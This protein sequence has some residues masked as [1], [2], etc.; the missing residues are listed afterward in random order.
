MLA[1]SRPHREP[2]EFGMGRCP[3]FA[4]TARGAG[5]AARFSRF[6]NGAASSRMHPI[7]SCATGLRVRFL[8][9][10][11]AV[12][13]CQRGSAIGSTLIDDGFGPNFSMESGISVRNRPVGIKLLRRGKE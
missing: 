3:Y 10:T 1:S 13:W 4:E 6:A 9:V 12:G 8:R 2:Q 7:K 11:M 5:A